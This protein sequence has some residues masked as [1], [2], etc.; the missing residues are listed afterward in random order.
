MAFPPKSL[1]PR[2]RADGSD[3]NES[4]SF[5]AAAVNNLNSIVYNMGDR[6]LCRTQTPR[7]HWRFTGHRGIRST[8]PRPP[9]VCLVFAMHKTLQENAIRPVPEE[10][11]RLISER[12]IID[13]IFSA[14]ME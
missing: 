13:R 3:N 9:H 6:D 14:V 12:A 1:T 4:E 8:A 11:G 2:H 10:S 5:K 7:L